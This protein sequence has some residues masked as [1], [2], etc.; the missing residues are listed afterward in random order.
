MKKVLAIITGIF[1]ITSWVLGSI[2]IT[3][4]YVNPS[5]RIKGTKSVSI[6]II[7]MRTDPSDQAS[8]TYLLRAWD[9]SAA[10]TRTDIPLD[11]VIRQLLDGKD[12]SPQPNVVESYLNQAVVGANTA[13]TI[14]VD[15]GT[16]F[17]NN[18]PIAIA[19]TYNQLTNNTGVCYGIVSSLSD[20]TTIQLILPITVDYPIGA[21]VQQLNPKGASTNQNG[22]LGLKAKFERPL[23]PVT[24]SVS[25]TTSTGGKLRVGWTASASTVATYYDLYV[26]QTAISGN[27]ENT[28]PAYR[29]ATWSINTASISTGLLITTPLSTTGYYVYIVSKDAVGIHDVNRSNILGTSQ[30]YISSP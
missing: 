6:D 8:E 1:L 22:E 9:N 16:G 15:N 21:I 17:L 13:V 10:T 18:Q 26:S 19:S 3:Q 28:I 2:T 27:F 24:L 4:E 20:T 25:T 12:S 29:N 11:A 7:S 14:Y 23:P 5:N 30:A